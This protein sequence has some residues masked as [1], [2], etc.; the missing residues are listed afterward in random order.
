MLEEGDTVGSVNNSKVMNISQIY[1]EEREDE[2]TV[3][4]SA[5]P[6]ED[7]GVHFEVAGHTQSTSSYGGS[8]EFDEYLE[9]IEVAPSLSRRD[10]S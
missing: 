9:D 5:T 2:A 7:A 8:E 6:F 4:R 1:I 10:S 3:P